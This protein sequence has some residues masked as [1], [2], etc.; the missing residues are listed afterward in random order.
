MYIP[1]H[2]H[3]QI[4]VRPLI[5][6]RPLA[7]PFLLVSAA[8]VGLIAVKEAGK[9]VDRAL[10]VTPIVSVCAVG[11]KGYES[12]VFASSIPPGFAVI[13]YSSI[14]TVVGTTSG[15]TVRLVELMIPTEFPT[16]V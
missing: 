10:F 2:M 7:A 5:A 13:L 3:M 4:P 16:W 14:M 11:W 9:V 1:T 8:V 6:V 15:P 12:V